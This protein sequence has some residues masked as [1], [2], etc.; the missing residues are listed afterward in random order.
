MKK[1]IKKKT[2]KGK[3]ESLEN[4]SKHKTYYKAKKLI[5][6]ISNHKGYTAEP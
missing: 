5:N 2:M 6:K 3:R 1:K 4:K